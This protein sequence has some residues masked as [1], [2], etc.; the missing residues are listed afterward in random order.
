MMNARTRNATDK[1]FRKERF[2]PI[3][4]FPLGK[5]LTLKE[6]IRRC[7]TFNDYKTDGIIKAVLKELHNL[8]ITYNVYLI[9]VKSFIND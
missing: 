4:R 6:V 7:L 8:R 2:A 9:S 1:I 3:K 5:M